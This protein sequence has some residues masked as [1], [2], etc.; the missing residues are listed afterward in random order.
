MAATRDE[1][2][3]PLRW[4]GFFGFPEEPTLCYVRARRCFWVT[5]PPAQQAAH[6]SSARHHPPPAHRPRAGRETRHGHASEVP[7]ALCPGCRASEFFE[8]GV[9][10][11]AVEWSTAQAGFPKYPCICLLCGTLGYPL[12]YRTHPGA[13]I[14]R[15]SGRPRGRRG[16]LGSAGHR[17]VFQTSRTQRLKPREKAR[18]EN[19]AGK[20]SPTE[21]SADGAVCISAAPHPGDCVFVR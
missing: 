8:N 11:K 17:T 6:V 14:H 15:H 20:T 21:C 13:P 10:H 2:S 12:L 19:R 5:G 1:V 9:C 4:R 3:E 7:R 16:R 18:L